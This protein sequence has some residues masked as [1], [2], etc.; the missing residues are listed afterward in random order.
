MKWNLY[1]RAL[2]WKEFFF[3]LL[4][5]GIFLVEIFWLHYN[6]VNQSTKIIAGNILHTGMAVLI[7]TFIKTEL[8]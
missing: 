2:Y 5:I 8:R 3:I 1:A 6:E 7:F 4:L